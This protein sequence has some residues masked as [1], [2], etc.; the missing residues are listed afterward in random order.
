MAH[1]KPN[2][3]G[4]TIPLGLVFCWKK[5]RPDPKDCRL[6]APRIQKSSAPLYPKYQK[7]TG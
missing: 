7:P 2:W 6:L 5:A 3:V 1:L 4:R